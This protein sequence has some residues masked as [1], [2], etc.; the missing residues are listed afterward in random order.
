[1]R[2]AH[3][4][5]CRAAHLGT[6]DHRRS[7]AGLAALLVLLG[8]GAPRVA[9]AFQCTPAGRCYV[10]VAWPSRVV[11]YIVRVPNGSGVTPDALERVVIRAFARW[12]DVDCSDLE[13]VSAGAI[14]SNVRDESV[15]EVV[16]IPRG[17]QDGGRDPSA[18]A[19]TVVSFSTT[20][21]KILG[22]RIEINEEFLEFT[23]I[24]TQECATAF[25]LESVLTHEAGHFVGLAHPCELAAGVTEC[26][27][28]TC[29]D[30]LANLPPGGSMPT[31][32]PILGVCEDALRTLEEDD[33]AG[34]CTLYPAG[35][36]TIPCFGLPDQDEPYVSNEAWGCSSYREPRRGKGARGEGG[37][38]AALAWVLIALALLLLR[39]VGRA[40]NR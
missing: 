17:W 23:D 36:P 34:L 30:L 12:N 15:N 38:A 31:M 6:D 33:R 19:V 3:A 28:P 21:G 13:V 26:P 35:E 25:D 18:A 40:T 39:G 16:T 22:A 2:T 7:A 11:P 14:A 20:S 27:V 29:D 5:R 4:V 8:V 24:R 9:S 32:F 10:N 37:A 1:M